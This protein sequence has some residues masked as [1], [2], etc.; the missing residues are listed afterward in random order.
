MGFSDACIDFIHMMSFLLVLGFSDQYLEEWLKLSNG[1][2]K[3]LHTE[4]HAGKIEACRG[5]FPQL[6]KRFLTEMNVSDRIDWS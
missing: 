4:V 2:M 5:N 3:W 6:W 1:F